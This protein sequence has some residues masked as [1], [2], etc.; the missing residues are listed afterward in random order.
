MDRQMGIVGEARRPTLV[1]Q[2][3]IENCR[4]RLDAIVLCIQLSRFSH[5]RIAEELG[6]DKGH[7]SRMLQ[8]KAYFPDTKSVRLME[9]CGNMAPLQ[10]EMYAMGMVTTEVP[11]RRH[12]DFGGRRGEWREAA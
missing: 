4:H 3:L 7:L 11:K 5:E 10:F 8:G 2:A 9:F 6:I 12:S 1:P